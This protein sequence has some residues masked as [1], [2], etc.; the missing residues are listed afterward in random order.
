[1]PFF[2]LER[3]DSENPSSQ[4]MRFFF[5]LKADEIQNYLAKTA[6]ADKQKFVPMLTIFNVMNAGKCT[7]KVNRCKFLS[8]T[9]FYKKAF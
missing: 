9:H 4:L 8:L 7:F 2:L 3:I 1:M 5:T 6:M